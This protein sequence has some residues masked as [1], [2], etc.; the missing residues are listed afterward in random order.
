MGKVTG[1]MEYE[2]IEEGYKP[3]AERVKHYKEFVIGL[4]DAQAKVQGAR[5]MDCGTPFCNNGCPVNNIIPDFNDLVYRGD[6]K[7]AIDRAAQHQQLPRVHRPHLPRAVR[8]GLHAQRERRRGG[9]QVDRARH[10]RP[11]WAEG[12]V[13][14]AATPSTRPARRWPWWAPARP[15]WR[16]RSNWRAPATT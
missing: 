12:W 7:N 11:A 6:W 13:Q 1:F 5:C 8:G 10:H 9:H 4:D 15:A 2:R 14:A 16:R 3:V